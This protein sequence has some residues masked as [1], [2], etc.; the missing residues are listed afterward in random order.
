MTLSFLTLNI[1]KGNLLASVISFLEKENPDIVTLQEVFNGSDPSLDERFRSFSLIKER[2]DFPQAVFSPAFLDV[3]NEIKV[4]N[5]NAIYSKYPIVSTE[6]R[7]YDI[8]YG[9]YVD[10]PDTYARCPRNLQE[11]RVKLSDGRILHVFNT[12]GIWGLDGADNQRRFEMSQTI[13]KAV[14]GKTPTILAGDFNLQPTTQT[15]RNIEKELCNV[16][17]GELTSTFNMK[18]KENLGYKTAVVDMVFV[19]KD[20][21]MLSNSCPQIDVSDHLP[22]CCRFEV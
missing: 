14:S 10:G 12:Q 3:A 20:I 6:T 16:F 22:L 2:L 15:I 1:W 17:K 9:N 5:G 18:R 8:P 21:R 13:V 11:V 7:F 4:E 19:S